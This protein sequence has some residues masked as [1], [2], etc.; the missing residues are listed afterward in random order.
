MVAALGVAVVGAGELMLHWTGSF[1]FPEGHGPFDF[2]LGI[3]RE[4]LVTGHFLTVLSVPAYFLGYW[5]V[6]RRLAPMPAAYRQAFFAL[7][8]YVLTMAA[9]WIGSRAY[10]GLSLQ[11]ADTAALREQ[12][13]AEYELLLETL[14]WLLR[15]GMI[16]LSLA[17]ALPVL[18]RRTSF[19]AWM[20]ALNPFALLM[21]VFSSLLVPALGPHLVPAALNVA[22]VPFFLLC[23]FAPQ[24]D[25][26]TPEPPQ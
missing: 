15:I 5:Q 12:L 3:P 8:L 26:G 25:R 13:S 18:L 7:S 19:P 6:S 2:L 16:L 4:R 14:I 21:L 1:D 22:H 24:L 10:L 17:F 9:I 23:A 20:A 11:L